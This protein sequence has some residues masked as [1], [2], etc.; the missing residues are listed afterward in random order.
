MPRRVVITGIGVFSPVGIG[1]DEYVRSLLSGTSGVAAVTRFETGTFPIRFAAEV[2]AFKPRDYIPK[3]HRKAIKVMSW[4]VQLGVAAAMAAVED[5]GIIT[6]T[7]RVDPTRLGTSFGCG[8]IAS[9][10]DEMGEAFAAAVIDGRFDVRTFGTEAMRTFFPLWLLKYLPNMPA[11]HVSIFCDT[12]G[13]NNSITSG[14]CASTQALGEARR[15]IERGAA[16]VMIAGGVDAKINPIS[17]V[18]YYLLNATTTADGDPKTLSRPFEKSR[19]GFVIGEG[20]AG[21]ILEEYEHARARGATI[22]AELKG[23]GS[24]CDA[25]RVDEPHPDGRGARIAMQNAL[26]TAGL[27]ASDIDAVFASANGSVAGDRAE[28]RAINAVFGTGRDDAVPVTSTKSMIGFISAGSGVLDVAA[29]VGAIAEG[30]IPPTLN[31][32]EPDPECNVNVVANTAR[33]AALDHVMIS[34]GGF[35]G[36]HAAVVI[37]R[38]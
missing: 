1:Q 10:V 25:W 3:Q 15:V 13:P 8:H 30:V 23:Y 31:Y 36:Q 34:S 9:N 22:Y 5:A 7:G 20:G 24:G 29:A 35:G 28:S 12:Q 38:C 21:L 37:S 26:R 4:D 11:C 2:P 14:D 16:D 33:K 18:R 17:F 19:S 27:N 32:D 6:E